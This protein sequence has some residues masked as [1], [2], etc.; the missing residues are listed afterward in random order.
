MKWNIRC[1]AIQSNE[2]DGIKK[3]RVY[4]GVVIGDNADEAAI[5]IRT[6]K[7]RVLYFADGFRQ[8]FI[9][10]ACCNADIIVPSGSPCDTYGDCAECPYYNQDFG[11]T[12]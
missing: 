5:S 4:S 6:S 7:G 1:K 8:N 10:V 11:C 2:H 12:D 9:L 3:N